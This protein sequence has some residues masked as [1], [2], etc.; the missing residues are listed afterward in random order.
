MLPIIAEHKMPVPFTSLVAVNVVLIPPL[1]KSVSV[2][3]TSVPYKNEI[4]YPLVLVAHSNVTVSLIYTYC[5]TGTVV[6]I[7]IIEYSNSILYHLTHNYQQQE[8]EIDTI[9]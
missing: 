5:V 9:L 7:P 8:Q 4:V 6:N 1:G 3:I 2:A